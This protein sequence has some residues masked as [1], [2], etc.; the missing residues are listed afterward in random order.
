MLDF[1]LRSWYT[2]F[3]GCGRPKYITHKMPQAC[4]GGCTVVI[5]GTANATDASLGFFV[6]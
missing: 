1:A 3:S 4:G 5:Y 6:V 2:G